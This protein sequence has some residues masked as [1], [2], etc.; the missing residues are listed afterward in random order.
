MSTHALTE[1]AMTMNLS[2]SLWQG[3][4]LDKEA[5]RKV[6]SQAGAALDAA[7]VNKHLVPKEALAPVVTAAGAVRTHFYE[8]TLPW[9]DNGDRLMTRKLFLTFIPAHETLVREFETAVETFL[10][11]DYPH[12]IAQAEFRMGDMFN[13]DDYPPVSEL[14]RR[15]RVNLDFDA[16]TTANDF[17]VAIDQEHVDRVKAAMER[18]A[19]ERIAGAMAD[20]WRRLGETVGYFHE[21][22]AN[23][24][25]VFR[26]STVEN[27]HDLLELIPGLNVLDDP[28]IEQVRALI[29]EKL[30][31]AAAKEI[32]K[33]PEYRAELAGEAKQIID[34][35]QGFM[36]AFSA[37]QAKAA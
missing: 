20:I 4:R 15:F 14:R 23:P 34:T 22:M 1:R 17:R 26:D 6:T 5:S 13:P 16:I 37:P 24:E 9:R 31:G 36:N 35:M 12:A 30:G 27:V 33:D 2:I 28:A 25:A 7:R 8:N 3:Y 29:E 32:R 18:A 10:T 11:R 19:E 21:R